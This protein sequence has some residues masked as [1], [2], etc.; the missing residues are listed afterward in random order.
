MSSRVSSRRG[1]FHSDYRS[2]DNQD[3]SRSLRATGSQI[4]SADFVITV[5]PRVDPKLPPGGDP[6]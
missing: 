2:S 4:S 3:L 5:S 1:S 6:A